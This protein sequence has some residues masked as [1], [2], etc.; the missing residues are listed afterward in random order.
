MA[1]VIRP[2]SY[3]E[4]LDAPNA[5]ELLAEYEAECALPELAPADPQP[6]L[7][8]MMEKAGHYHVFGI[9]GEDVLIGFIGMID[10]PVPHYGKHIVSTESLFVMD[11]YRSAGLWNQMHE[12]IKQYGRQHGCSALQIVAPAWS[13]LALLLQASSKI[14]LSN[15]V[16]IERL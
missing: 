5:R 10:W 2:V 7:Y 12:F 15:L 14:R 11:E 4:I 3:R 6:Q 9:F 16:F 8:E 13:R 1:A